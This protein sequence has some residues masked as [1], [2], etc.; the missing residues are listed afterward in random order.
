MA[1]IS[2]QLSMSL[3]G[4]IARP[5]DSPGPIFD[6][7]DAGEVEVHWPGNDMVSRVA[8]A[9]ARHLEEIIREAG[10]LVVGRRVFDITDGWGGSHPAGVPV[11]V[12]THRP[13]DE[14][15]ERHP[16]APFTFVHQGVEQAVALASEVAGA[17]TVGL[18]GP[19]IARQA[20]S[21]G[22]LDE[23]RIDLAPVLLGRGIRFFGDGG[24]DPILFDDPDVV[25]SERVTHLRY[26]I[27]R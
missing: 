23:V 5:D 20:L 24:P 18:A 4:F 17:K 1:T 26:R 25:V 2:V 22:L 6:W 7:Y 14:W 8:P 16:D 9:S 13:A 21:V 27:R 15:S 10:A 11:F 3:D 12:V 19:D